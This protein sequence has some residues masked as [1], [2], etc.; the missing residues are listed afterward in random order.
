MPSLSALCLSVA[1]FSSVFYSL[2]SPHLKILMCFTSSL[3]PPPPL[4]CSL[5]MSLL[6]HT[7]LGTS[8]THLGYHRRR[9]SIFR[10]E[11]R[12]LLVL[13]KSEFQMAVVSTSVAL[14]VGL[15]QQVWGMK[16]KALMEI[17]RATEH[18]IL[19]MQICNEFNSILCVPYD[20]GFCC[21]SLPRL[22]AARLV[23]AWF[24][25]VW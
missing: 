16:K 18:E 4:V 6:L 10:T 3:R 23:S 24:V 12:E 11:T 20:P 17:K 19:K 9:L 5:N 15:K 21:E 8:D 2:H 7:A 13:L 14:E 22:T 1:H 25:H